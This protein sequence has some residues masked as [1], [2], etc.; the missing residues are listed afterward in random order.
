MLEITENKKNEVP[1]WHKLCLTIKEASVY[2]NIG[3]DKLR[4]IIR[5]SKC[6]FVLYK[7]KHILIKREAFEKWVNTQ[8]VI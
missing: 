6:S 3:E 2:S 4:E 8:E 1:I 5:N 7:S